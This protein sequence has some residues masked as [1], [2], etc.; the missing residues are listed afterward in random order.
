MK[1]VHLTA[2]TFH[3]GPERQMLGLAEA[4]DGDAESAFLSFAEGGRCAPFLTAARRQG[5]E[6]TE[7]KNDTPYF[8]SAVRE[9]AEH[10]DRLGADVLCCHG[11]KANLLGRPA[12][13]RRGVPAVAVSRRVR[14]PTW[15]VCR[16]VPRSSVGGPGGG[17]ACGGLPPG[18]PAVTG[19]GRGWGRGR[20][21]GLRG[22]VGHGRHPS[23]AVSCRG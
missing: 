3:G 15:R 12:A 2:S 8:R 6:A 9:I 7:L 4:L 19:G 23:A 5:N 14:R 16:V 11:Y 1:I 10:L 20:R 21:G 13:R 18:A 17:A 22:L